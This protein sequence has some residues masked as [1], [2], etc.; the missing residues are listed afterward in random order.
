MIYLKLRTDSKLRKDGSEQVTPLIVTTPRKYSKNKKEKA[1][2]R[3][4]CQLITG[5]H[6]SG[7][8]RWLLRLHSKHTEIWG[9]KDKACPVYISAL[10]PLSAWYEHDYLIRWY[11]AQEEKR[12]LADQ[13]HIHRPW[14]KLSQQQRLDQLPIYITENKAM[15][16]VDDAHKLTGRKS[17]LARECVILSKRWII[18]ALAENRLPPSLRTVVERRQPQRT[19][20]ESD[21][22]YDATGLLTWFL[23]AAAF[24]AGW[25]ELSLILGGL[26]ML[27]SGRR[28]ARPD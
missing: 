9:S 20:L 5:A 19:Q 10:T 1:L 25:W 28:A 27:G 6:D 23:I 22:S 7:K 3:M 2:K 11:N 8:T 14:N 13:E 16:F 21:V 24:V 4:S 17:Q 15:C 26:K 18:T 12:V